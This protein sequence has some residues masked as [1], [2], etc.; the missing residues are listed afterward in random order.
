VDLRLTKLFSFPTP[1]SHKKNG[2][3]RKLQ[4]LEFTIDAFNVFNHPNTP[5]IV[6]ELGAHYF[7][8]ATTTNMA[9]TLQ[10]SVKYSF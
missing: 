10:L 3:D 9:R 1:F 2:S 6:G 4:N 5:I 7:G 8:Q